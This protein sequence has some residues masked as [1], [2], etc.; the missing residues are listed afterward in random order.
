MH[1]LATAVGLELL[2][3]I[4]L[5]LAGQIWRVGHDGQAH[6]PMGGGAELRFLATDFGVSGEC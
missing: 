3:Q 1:T 2:G 5:G 4:L 6:R